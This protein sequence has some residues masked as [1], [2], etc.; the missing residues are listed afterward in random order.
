[1]M[2]EVSSNSSVYRGEDV[3]SRYR[4]GLL[5]ATGMT[6]GEVERPLVAVVNSW[7]E[8]H[9]GHCHLRR[10]SERV[11]GGVRA[12]G[13]TPAE[14]NTI[15]LCDGLANGH[16]GMK[17][18]LPSRELIADAVELSIRAHCFD[19][20]VMVAS[21]DKILPAYLMAAA[22]LD[23]PTIL[24]TGGP[25][26]PP[27]WPREKMRM[28]IT[29]M[30]ERGERTAAGEFDQEDIEEMTYCYFRCPG[31]CWGMGTANT[32]ACMTEAVGMALPGDAT[33][34]SVHSEKD[35]LAYEAGKQIMALLEAGI[36]ASAIITPESIHN[37]LT[38]DMAI[39][40]S[41]NTVLHIPAIAE[42]A[43]VEIELAQ[44]DE[45]ARNTP[46]LCAVEPSGPYF[47]TELGEAGG[48]PV[49][50]K[51]LD[52]L[53]NADA[54]TVTGKTV[55][56]NLADVRPYENEV[57]RDMSNPVRP[58]GGVAVLRGNLT[59]EGAVIKQV[60]VDESMR[61]FEG[62]A[63]VFEREEDAI[64]AVKDGRIEQGDAIVVR[65]EGKRG[66][67]GMREMAFLRFFMQMSGLE[68]NTYLITDGRFSGYTS[69]PC[70]GYLLPEAA[71]G[72]PIAVV[73]DG[74]RISVDIDDRKLDLLVSDDELAARLKAW[75]PPEPK[76]TKGCLAR[77]AATVAASR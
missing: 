59:P 48:I 46:Y 43:G 56:E 55:G 74:D 40:G 58:Y 41:L 7:N 12:A 54:M 69:G 76:V 14:F 42:E 63:K 61:K 37:M 23:I 2:K 47:V 65:Y 50:M 20:M 77:Y 11:K 35:R 51:K 21:C 16:E 30:P 17:Y 44:F 29:N 19:A 1:M 66:G 62:P 71:A 3:L 15:S 13:G 33:V 57:I 24:V 8:I 28:G 4:R 39:G 6:R 64:E 70:I 52:S 34:P 73:R 31:A 10:L 32:M 9:P 68:D 49:V 67:P 26:V 53:L 38:V 60:G 72:G 5:Y 18:I 75:N 45:T 36:T 27:Y 22:R 25:M